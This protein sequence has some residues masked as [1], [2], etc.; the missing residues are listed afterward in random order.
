MNAFELSRKFWDFAYEN[1]EK[2]KPNHIAMYFFAIEHCNRLGWKEKFGF[3]RAMVM[4]AIG[5][6]S[7][8]TFISTLTD[9]VDFGF[10][11]MVEKS[12][13]QYS[14]NIIALS[15]FNNAID[16]ALDR[17]N[18][19]KASCSIKKSE[20]TI[21]STVQSTVQS[22]DTIIKPINNKPINNYDD[23][24]TRDENFEKKEKAKHFLKN[25]KPTQIERIIMQHKLSVEHY[26][27]KVDEFV[28]KKFDWGEDASWKDE[29]D[30]AKNFEF[31]LPS[32][33]KRLVNEYKNWTEEDF[34]AD[35]EKNKKGYSP[36]MLTLFFRHFKQKTPTGEM[37]FQSKKAWN[38]EDQLKIWKQNEIKRNTY[39]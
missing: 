21:Q 32:N 25:A 29:D 24:N 35:I 39:S 2:I 10:I 11:K 23:D 1:P 22:T 28:E 7:Y 27:E 31:W 33:Y 26:E 37:L 20:S 30:M 5:I 6:K 34:R 17:A 15:K 8:N 9:L 12:K 36:K 13:N 16:K 14:A 19:L 18:G 38:T 3:P 4:D